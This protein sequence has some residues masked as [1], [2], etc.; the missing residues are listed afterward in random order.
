MEAK[1]DSCTVLLMGWACVIG[2]DKALRQIPTLLYASSTGACNVLVDSVM[3][4]R[5]NTG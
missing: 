4:L 2:C 3:A 5:G 1:A